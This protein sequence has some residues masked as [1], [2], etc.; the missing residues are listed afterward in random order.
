MCSERKGLNQI[1]NSTRKPSV[2]EEYF[3]RV[4]D[5]IFGVLIAARQLFSYFHICILKRFGS[6]WGVFYFGISVLSGRF[7]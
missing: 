5:C 7:V 2:L 6:S 4:T 1:K 3:S